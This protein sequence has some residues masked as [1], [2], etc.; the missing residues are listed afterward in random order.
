MRDSPFPNG[1]CTSPLDIL[2]VE[3]TNT[4]LRVAL[5]LSLTS[6]SPPDFQGIPQ[7]LEM[8]P[9]FRCRP[10]IIFFALLAYV[11]FP[12]HTNTCRSFCP[13]GLPVIALD[14]LPF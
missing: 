8:T 9:A 11:D 1:F 3:K 2:L 4:C 6:L 12:A 13:K 7:L 5:H 10:C 14:F